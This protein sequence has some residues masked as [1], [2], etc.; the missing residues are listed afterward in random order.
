MPFSTLSIIIVL[1]RSKSIEVT[2]FITLTKIIN[3]LENPPGYTRTYSQVFFYNQLSFFRLDD[4]L[5]VVE[6]KIARNI[7]WRVLA[8]QL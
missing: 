3:S 8:M 1:L 6:K 2:D 7:S 5:P 4:R